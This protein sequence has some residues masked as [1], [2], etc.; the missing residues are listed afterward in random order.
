MTFS[1]QVKKEIAK[2]KPNNRSKNKGPFA[3]G[4]KLFG[5][6]E[7]IEELDSEMVKTENLPSFISG[8][9]ISC[10]TVSEPNKG[11]HLEFISPN[12]F[13]SDKLFEILSKLGYPPKSIERR[14][15]IVLYY[16]ESEQIEDILAI[17]GASNCAL[18][19]M[20]TKIY[21]DLVNRTNRA[22][23]CEIANIDKTLR[24]SQKQMEEIDFLRDNDLIKTL[25][26]EIEEVVAI[27]IQNPSASLSEMAE[28]LGISKSGVNHR[29]QKLS[30]ICEEYKNKIQ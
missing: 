10:G 26:K 6:N 9:F 29:I 18:E 19:I 20:G 24:T 12:D 13:L 11:Y 23:N 28:T 15:K 27:R 22:S 4:I 21:K 8:A 2:F 17:M 3:Y 16:K 25:P 5:S 7:V 1:E 14:G 30:K